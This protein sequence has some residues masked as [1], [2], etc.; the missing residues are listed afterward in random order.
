MANF[1]MVEV[2]SVNSTVPRSKFED[3]DLDILADLIL[4]SGGIL[5]PLILKKIGFEKYE[6]VGG[7]FEYYAAVRAREKNPNKGEIVNAMIISSEKEDAALNQIALLK[8]GDTEKTEIGELLDQKLKP[9]YAKINQ[10][11][12]SPPV[13]TE[14]LNSDEKLQVIENKLEYL[15]SV[16]ESLTI[17]IKQGTEAVKLEKLNLLTA[18]EEEIKMVLEDNGVTVS[19]RKSALAAIKYWQQSGKTLNWENLRKSTDKKTGHGIPGFGIQTYQKLK[20]ITEIRAE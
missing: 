10:L 17:L 5:K 18:T 9:I 14:K 11:I 6:V 15:S 1:L 7:H 3:T 4:E 12:S 2:E 16:V 8:G 13:N 20:S 19:Q